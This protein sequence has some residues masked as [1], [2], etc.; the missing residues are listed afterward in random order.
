MAQ[1]IKL[2]NA[3]YFSVPAVQLPKSG[4]GSAIFTDV[5]DTTA[6]ASDVAQGKYFYTASG[7]R[8]AGT[9]S[10]GGGGVVDDVTTL[11]TGGDYHA[12][13][14]Q[15]ITGTVS[16]TE[17][18][19]HDVGQYKYAE[20]NVSGGGGGGSYGTYT[21]TASNSTASNYTG[22]MTVDT[23]GVSA[24]QLTA[25]TVPYIVRPKTD[26]PFIGRCELNEDGYLYVLVIGNSATYWPTLTAVSGTAT[27][28]TGSYPPTSQIWTGENGGNT[29]A[30][31]YVYVIYKVSNGAVLTESYYNNN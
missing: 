18:G 7:V 5:T 17:N 22:I 27:L 8:T 19:T 14:G 20:V 9:G 23:I 16:I 31:P 24:S 10:G 30:H 2:L 26:T 4:G 11:P 15:A 13:S 28:M 1:D 12:I 6:G 29:Y 21:V 3:T 25:Y